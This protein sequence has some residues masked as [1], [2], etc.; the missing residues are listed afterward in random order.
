MVSALAV[1]LAALS[2]Q[3]G[4]LAPPLSE[5]LLS[6]VGLRVAT[7]LA[8][9]QAVGETVF[10]AADGAALTSADVVPLVDGKVLTLRAAAGTFPARVERVDTVTG[11]ALLRPTSPL[12]GVAYATVAPSVP[13]GVGLAML[14]SGSARAAVTRVNVP[15]LVGEARAFT[16]LTEVRLES[17]QG[18]VSGAPVFDTQGR[19]IAV[20]SSSLNGT[21]SATVSATA[22]GPAQPIVAF[23]VT[24]L[25]IRRAL[26]GLL[27]P[28]GA[29]RHPYVGIR[30][31]EQEGGK[32][33]V[34]A[35][36]P[37]GPAASVGVKAGERIVRAGT[38]TVQSALDVATYLFLLEPG[39]MA[40][41]TLESQ[42][43]R[44]TLMVPVVPMPPAK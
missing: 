41:L 6:Y 14:P 8:D 11:L 30:Y 4:S 42:G 20:L 31:A 35:T 23:S 29:S 9:D 17:T 16:P 18:T 26:A 1:A 27:D 34:T 28:K 32:V 21:A 5:G 24:S 33:V 36:S 43:V 37:G 22:I 2:G 39:S 10:V 38:T 15:G 19:L 7:V 25:S 12:T 13:L 40:I 44:R 3:Q